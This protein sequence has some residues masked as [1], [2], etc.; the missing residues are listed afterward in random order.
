[1][2]QERHREWVTA[3][4]AAAI[5]GVSYQTMRRWADERKVRH[6][7]LPGGT[8]RFERADI[9]ALLTPVEPE[10]PDELAG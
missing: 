7:R 1:M 8:L 2:N 5:V 6:V 10:V 4:E 3:R 9:E